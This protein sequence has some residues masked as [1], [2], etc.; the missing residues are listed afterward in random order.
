MGISWL[1]N[2]EPTCGS[3]EGLLDPHLPGFQRH[4]TAA[5]EGEPCL[6]QAPGPGPATHPRAA[7][8]VFRNRGYKE[9]H[10]SLSS[11]GNQQRSERASSAERRPGCLIL[12]TQAALSAL[13]PRTFVLSLQVAPVGI[14][15]TQPTG[16][17]VHSLLSP[18]IGTSLCLYHLN[19]SSFVL[20]VDLTES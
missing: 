2:R 3:S 15:H 9:E 4:L 18:N 1:L 13:L 16:V 10:L 20:V 17:Y 12:G 14:F 5:V 8:R 7:S 11:L 6:T 19:V